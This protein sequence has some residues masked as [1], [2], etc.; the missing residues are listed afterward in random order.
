MSSKLSVRLLVGETPVMLNQW[1]IYKK[2]EQK[3]FMWILTGVYSLIILFT[4]N[5]LTAHSI[6]IPRP[7]QWR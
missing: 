7:P 6:R 4:N 1:T 2:K 5:L 3:I